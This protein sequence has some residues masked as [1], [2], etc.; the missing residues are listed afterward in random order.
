MRR[1]CRG[2][3]GLGGCRRFLFGF[4]FL[5]GLLCVLR[6]GKVGWLGMKC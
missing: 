3:L 1:L 5:G 4:F 6:K 2:G